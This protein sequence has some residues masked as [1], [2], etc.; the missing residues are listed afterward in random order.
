MSGKG[1]AVGAA[2]AVADGDGV[3]EGDASC[4]CATDAKDSNSR[5]TTGNGARRANI[6]TLSAE[7]REWVLDWDRA[8][9]I[10]CVVPSAIN[11]GMINIAVMSSFAS[12]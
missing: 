7:A 11:N 8:K 4:A 6:I 10:R 9:T 2:V 12:S 5:L 3:G 1:T